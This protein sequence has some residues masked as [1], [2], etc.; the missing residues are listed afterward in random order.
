[1]QRMRDVLRGSLARSLRE[2]SPEDRLAAAWPVACGPALANRGEVLRLDEEGVLHVC[3][4]GP[5]WLRQFFDVRSQLA[6]DLARIS[7]VALSGI[8]FEEKGSAGPQPWP[9]KIQ[10]HEQ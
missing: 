9:R 1:M 5:G 2:L 7:G 6:A 8:H 3:V 10:E 4:T